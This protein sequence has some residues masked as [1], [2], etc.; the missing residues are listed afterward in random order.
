MPKPKMTTWGPTMADEH[1]HE[2]A[3]RKDK[4]VTVVT[5]EKFPDGRLTMSGYDEREVENGRV[6]D[7]IDEFSERHNKRAA[8]DQPR[9]RD[10]ISAAM[11]HLN[12]T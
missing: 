4:P 10:I 3:L 9:R 2:R 5:L 6:F 1:G 7:L 11:R 8:P 12:N